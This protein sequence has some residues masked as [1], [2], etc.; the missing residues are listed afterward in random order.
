MK[1]VT[2]DELLELL[3]QLPAP[4]IRQ[5]VV[6]GDIGD[7]SFSVPI[8]ATKVENGNLVLIVGSI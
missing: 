6:K 1:A 7:V 5:I 4:L 2:P 8:K 3:G